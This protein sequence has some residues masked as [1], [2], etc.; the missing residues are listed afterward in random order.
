MQTVSIAS[1]F[2]IHATRNARRATLEVVYCEAPSICNIPCNQQSGC[3]STLSL[4]GGDNRIN[5]DGK[6]L[7]VGGMLALLK[8]TFSL[9]CNVCCCVQKIDLI[10]EL[11]KW[12]KMLISHVVRG[13]S[14]KVVVSPLFH[15]VYYTVSFNK[16]SVPVCF[17]CIPYINVFITGLD[18]IS[19]LQPYAS[20]VNS[21]TFIGCLGD[22]Q[23]DGRDIQLTDAVSQRNVKDTCPRLRSEEIP[24]ACNV[25]GGI[26]KCHVD[27][28]SASCTCEG[29][30]SHVHCDDGEYDIFTY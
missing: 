19:T 21:A 25:C 27:W 16:H 1:W 18:T 28:F 14:I 29:F 20:E 7:S 24:A 6:R 2:R 8:V 26:D 23:L 17:K 12:G 5:T 4:S 15:L 9:H 10:M 22:L 11:R 13:L 30:K 3:Y